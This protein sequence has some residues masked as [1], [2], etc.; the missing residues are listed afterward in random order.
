MTRRILAIVVALVFSIAGH[1]LIFASGWDLLRRMMQ[2]QPVPTNVVGIVGLVA[3][4]LLVAVAALTVAISSSGV[5]ALGVL[6]VVF[7]LLLPLMPFSL[8]SGSR[9]PTFQLIFLLGDLNIAFRDQMTTY[10]TIGTGVLVGVVLIVAGLA[11][12]GRTLRANP[13][14]IVVSIV[15]GILGAVGIGVALIGGFMIYRSMF[16]MMMGEIEV[17]GVAL[18]LLGSLLLAVAVVTVRW[19][20][21]G[22][23][24]LGAVVTALGIVV[25]VLPPSAIGAFARDLGVALTNVGVTGLLSLLGVVLVAVGVGVNVRTRRAARVVDPAS[26]P[27]LVDA[28][29]ESPDPQVV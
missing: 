17:L 11:A 21:A 1:L 19:S 4:I 8:F 26:A 18:L 28:A 10:F 29:A 9:P 23:I 27:A 20:S 2:F 14:A 5:I 15:V 24:V 25:A 16:Q 3:G 7:G 13:V 22:V 6:H 12:R